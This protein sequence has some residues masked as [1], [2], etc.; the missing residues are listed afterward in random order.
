MLRFLF[1]SLFV[2]GGSAFA[3]DP[4]EQLQFRVELDLTICQ[5][6]GDSH[7]CNDNDS[8]VSEL[9]TVPLL[10]T[11]EFEG[12]CVFGLARFEKVYVVRSEQWNEE[13][14]VLVRFVV[15]YIP[16]A[17][18]GGVYGPSLSLYPK[19]GGRSDDRWVHLRAKQFDDLSWIAFGGNT[20]DGKPKD[21]DRVEV[22]PG[23][24]I[25]EMKVLR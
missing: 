14:T 13:R 18:G 2:L 22:T 4:I 5:I 8:K 1:V 19:E 12:K 16:R 10:C 25:T 24:T 7:I 23:V 9:V 11:D 15:D 6:R 21:G 17:V 20:T 3:A